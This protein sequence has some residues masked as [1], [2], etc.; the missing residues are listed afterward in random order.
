M[1]NTIMTRTPAPTR[2][3][4]T[5]LARF[6]KRVQR[7]DGRERGAYVIPLDVP[8]PQNENYK[9][10]DDN[11]HAESSKKNFLERETYSAGERAQT[12]G[13][14]SVLWNYRTARPM[15]PGTRFA[16]AA[17]SDES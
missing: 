1:A 13:G 3:T 9:V 5:I 6:A 12:T 16:V 17:R 14:S 10:Y 7:D 2:Y 4:A 11:V 15:Q 8:L